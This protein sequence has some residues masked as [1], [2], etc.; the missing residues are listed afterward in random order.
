MIWTL[1]LLRKTAEQTQWGPTM[2]V[3]PADV[4]V[5]QW[6]E[7]AVS[8]RVTASYTFAMLKEDSCEYWRLKVG[9]C[10]L[11]DDMGHQWPGRALVKDA[12]ETFKRVHVSLSLRYVGCC[13]P[14]NC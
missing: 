7:Q 14:R 1:R 8:F 9:R 3:T 6:A 13:C 11:L 2:D 5:V 10:D 4:V 12:L